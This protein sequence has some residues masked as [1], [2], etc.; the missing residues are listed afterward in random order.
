MVFLLSL[1]E[2]ASDAFFLHLAK[3]I[4]AHL[5]EVFMLHLRIFVSAMHAVANHRTGV[6]VFI[7]ELTKLVF[8]FGDMLKT[9][10]ACFFQQTR[11]TIN[12]LGIIPSMHAHS[13]FSFESQFLDLVEKSHFLLQH[14]V[15]NTVMSSAKL[16]SLVQS[17][18]LGRV[19]V[20]EKTEFQMR[21][22]RVKARANK[23]ESSDNIM[24]AKDQ[25]VLP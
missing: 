7:V 11:R 10:R 25:P 19:L 3:I 18:A 20:I 17:S 14:F 24:Q 6:M 9:V 22:V 13:A 16:K 12:R 4:S 1:G 2:T 21:D 8:V 5:N 23:A 15:L